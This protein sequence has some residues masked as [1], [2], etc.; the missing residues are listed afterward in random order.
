ME[1]ILGMLRRRKVQEKEVNG[2]VLLL[3][4]ATAYN[5]SLTFKNFKKQVFQDSITVTGFSVFKCFFFLISNC[6]LTRFQVQI[7]LHYHCPTV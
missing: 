7:L 5:F 3:G 4:R 2:S 1:G 6:P